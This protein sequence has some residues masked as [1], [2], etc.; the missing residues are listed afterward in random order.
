MSM[1]VNTGFRRLRVNFV[2]SLCFESSHDQSFLVH[3]E[4]F[5]VMFSVPV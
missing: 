1:Y 2:D 4:V 3:I 5:H